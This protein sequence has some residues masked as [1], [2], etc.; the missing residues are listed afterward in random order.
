[1]VDEAARII[2]SVIL[3]GSL[4]LVPLSS[5]ARAQ[6]ALGAI[7]GFVVR[8]PGQP[9][10]DPREPRGKPIAGVQVTAIDSKGR[11]VATA[12]SDAKGAVH[13]DLPAGDY[14]LSTEFDRKSV[15]VIAGGLVQV[16]LSFAAM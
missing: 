9:R 5:C 1:M 2:V 3:I 16:V 6:P 13:F 8:Y 12:T 14:T 4:L 10:Y 11:T 7:D 15:H